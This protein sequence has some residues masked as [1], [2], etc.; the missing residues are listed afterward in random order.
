MHRVRRPRTIGF[1]S[2]Y[3]ARMMAAHHEHPNVPSLS[4]MQAL[5]DKL[6]HLLP[7]ELPEDAST[8]CDICQKDYSAEHIDPSED[9][10]VAIMLPC[11]HIFGEYCI[12]TWVRSTLH[13]FV[14]HVTNPSQ[15]ET[16][17][18]HKNK[19][20]CPMC[21]KLLVE[22]RRPEHEVFRPGHEVLQALAARDHRLLE[23][24]YQ[25]EE[26]HVLGITARDL[27]G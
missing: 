16:C 21:R 22:P 19:V 7:G 23:R 25:L 27:E 4:Q 5:K 18:T 14:P 15:F 8:T 11:K 10:E 12:N 3:R 26:R 6:R 2:S 9:A 20:T 1:S 13:V 17:K 24:Y